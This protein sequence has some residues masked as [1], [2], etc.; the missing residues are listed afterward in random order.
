MFSLM[1]EC[2]KK[3]NKLNNL[4]LRT[5]DNDNLKLMLVIFIMNCMTFTKVNTKKI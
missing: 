4:K 3:F 2:H 1:K 5:K